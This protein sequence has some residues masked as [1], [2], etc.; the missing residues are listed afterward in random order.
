MRRGK[1]VAVSA[2]T[3]FIT[4]VHTKDLQRNVIITDLFLLAMVIMRKHCPWNYDAQPD[5]SFALLHVIRAG[6]GNVVKQ[7]PQVLGDFVLNQAIL[8]RN[9]TLPNS[10]FLVAQDAFFEV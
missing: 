10:G 5:L 7:M 1:N 9:E 4:T 6:L 2:L 3:L 8:V